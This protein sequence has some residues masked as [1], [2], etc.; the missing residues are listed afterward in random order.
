MD[1]EEKAGS[2]FPRLHLAGVATLALLFFASASV[3]AEFLV[4]NMAPAAAGEIAAAAASTDFFSDIQLVATSAYVFDTTTGETLYERNAGAQLP[5]ASLT[6]IP[7]ALVVSEVLSQDSVITIPPHTP[8]DGGVK[9]FVDGSTWRVRDLMNFTLINSSNEGAELLA[10]AADE[11]IR[12]RYAEA[13]AGSAALWRMNALVRGLGLTHTYFLNVS[14][15][16]IS[17]SQ[18]GA[19]GSALEMAEVL[20][21]ASLRQP[22]LFAAT[23]RGGMLLLSEEGNRATAKNTD[24]VLGEIHGLIMG[25][26]G[27]TDL[28]GGNLAIAFDVGPAHPVVAVVLHSSDDGRFEDMMR[29]VA[30][31]EKTVAEGR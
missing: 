27:T 1:P 5:L 17:T 25:K 6:K 22:D 11:G 15:L 3:T 24:K 4:R 16:D 26:T 23:T 29:L 10:A 8:P 20:A 31:V 21:Y 7:L 19:Y 13:P 30:G 14:G 18:A 12:A 9:R 28:A 2:G